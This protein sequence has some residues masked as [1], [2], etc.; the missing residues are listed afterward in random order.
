[1]TARRSTFLIALLAIVGCGDSTELDRVASVVVTPSN[2]SIEVGLTV[3]FE[4][5]ALDANGALVPDIP[6]T[7]RSSDTG[8]ATIDDN[9]LATATALGTTAITASVGSAEPG[10]QVLDVDASQCLERI[11]VVLDP[12]Q[13]QAYGGGTCLFL[14]TGLAG[15]RYRVAIVRPT[16]IEDPAD[17][18][19]VRL[20]INPILTA[21]QM[22]GL[23]PVPLPDAV[24]AYSP[25]ASFV[26]IGSRI[27]GTR[28]A[29]DQ[30]IQEHTRRFHAQLRQR[31]MDLRL[32]TTDVLPSLATVGAADAPGLVDPPAQRDLFL[33]LECDPSATPSAVTLVNFNDDLAIYQDSDEHDSS[34]LSQ[35]AT[36]LM[37]DYFSEHVRDL[38]EVYWGETP[39]IDGNERVIITTTDA[40]P[41]SAAAAVF[42]GD[43]RSTAQCASSNEGEIMYFSSEIIEN[44]DD[45]DPSYLALSVMA[46]EMK[47]VTS[48]YHATARGTFHSLW[49]EEGTAEVSQA[50]S[51]RV[52]WASVGGPP[53][54]SVIDGN[55]IIDWNN[56]N[57]EIGP[58]AWGVVAQLADVIVHLWTQPNSLITNP[59]G[60]HEFH[61]FY[62]GGWHWHRFIGDAFGG[63]STPFADGPLF[64][65][66]TDSLTPAGPTALV[67]ATGRTFN[68]LF[69][70]MIVAMSFHAVGPEPPLGFTTWDLTTATAIFQ[71]PPEVAPPHRYPWP[72]TASVAGN[73]ARSYAAGVYSC[74]L[75]IVGGEYQAPESGARCGMGPSGY[76]FHE[77]V[78]DG[79]GAGAQVQVFGAASGQII[80]TRLN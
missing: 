5:E 47:H 7:W 64:V 76:R 3:Q 14:P 36:D 9:G 48:L 55:D 11:D 57:G 69:E 62:A 41:D 28:F 19:D 66:M 4:A 2:P 26:D 40:L 10:S 29:A 60:A 24:P 61:S 6:F 1:M 67:Q 34:P 27:D 30:R 44:M 33:V 65:E 8:V 31:E 25:S 74:P 16:L 13:H 12:G 59:E 37:L 77:F 38:M 72:V 42:S 80:V 22:A 46:H 39:D 18:P 49:I 70:D 71:N 21:E 50:M 73:P 17:V 51:S 35:S 68:Q 20:A 52:A 58:E 75:R 54:G 78:S 79:T 15:D 32:R 43:F 45:A 63:A 23:A 53:V 56:Q